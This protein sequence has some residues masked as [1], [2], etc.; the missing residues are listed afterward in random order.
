[1]L[2]S[3]ICIVIVIAAVVAAGIYFGYYDKDK[4]V[5]GNLQNVKDSFN[6]GLE[7]VKNHLNQYN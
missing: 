5:E 3:V 2:L 4:D 7:S 6:N 1:M